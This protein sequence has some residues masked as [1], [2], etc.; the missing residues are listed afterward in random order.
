MRVRHA[1]LLPAWEKALCV[2][3]RARRVV[4]VKARRVVLLA[5]WA[6]IQLVQIHG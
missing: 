3:L 6:R 1:A 5:I 2:E 4:I